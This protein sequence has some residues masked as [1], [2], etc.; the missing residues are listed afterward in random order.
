MNLIVMHVANAAFPSPFHQLDSSEA[1]LPV[2]LN[3]RVFPPRLFYGDSTSGS[4]LLKLPLVSR[5]S[6]LRYRP[7]HLRRSS[8]IFLSQGSSK[9]S[10]WLRVAFDKV[11]RK[12]VDVCGIS[13]P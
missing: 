1:T 10:S 7:R 8:H 5:A 4:F 3:S 2:V 12:A 6:S 13:T 11:S 9:T